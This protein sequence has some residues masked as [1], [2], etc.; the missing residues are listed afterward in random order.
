MR[1]AILTDKLPPA[2][3]Q[4]IIHEQNIPILPGQFARRQ[5]GSDNFISVLRGNYA[6]LL[7]SWMRKA[8]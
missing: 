7:G 1:G 4:F 3:S 2:H 6:T 5:H 8:D